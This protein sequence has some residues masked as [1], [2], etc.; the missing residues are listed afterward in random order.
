MNIFISKNKGFISKSKGVS[1]IEIMIVF[2]VTFIM[3]ASTLPSFIDKVIRAKVNESLSLAEP[4]K[5]A[6]LKTC[7]TNGTAVV[8]NNLEADYFYIPTG[9][10]E[11]YVDR[12][13]LGADCA[14]EFMVIIIWTGSTGAETNPILELST[15]GAGDNTWTCRVI[16]GDLRHVPST[17]HNSYRT[18]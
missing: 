18:I 13:L 10:K 11:D 16:Q 5:E 15:D 4:A 9:T 12:I 2:A 8:H 14:N 17:C 7:E 6:L 1:L 3:L